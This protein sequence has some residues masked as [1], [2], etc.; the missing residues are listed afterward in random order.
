M[1]IRFAGCSTL[2]VVPYET[3]ERAVEAQVKQRRIFDRD[4]PLYPRS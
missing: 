2:R 1:M 4:E 3:V